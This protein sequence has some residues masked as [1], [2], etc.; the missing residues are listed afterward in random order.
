VS[1]S[2]AT[3][4]DLEDDTGLENHAEIRF[5]DN[6]AIR[7]PTWRN[8]IRRGAALSVPRLPRPE[9]G[10]LGVPSDAVLRWDAPGGDSFGVLLWRDGE[11]PPAVPAIVADRFLRPAGLED[12]ASFSWQVVARSGDDT[13]AGPVWRFAVD[14]RPAPPPFSRGD[15]SGDGRF[16]IS[17]ASFVLDFLFRGGPS[18]ACLAAADANADGSL[19]VSDPLTTLIALFVTGDPLPAPFPGCGLPE[20]PRLDIRACAAVPACP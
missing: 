10:A 14:D 1:F 7:T 6:P 11:P 2:V 13:L 12:G 20:G 3:L 8:V 19:D 17:D 9:D 4:S 18:P 15:A 5:D 16:D